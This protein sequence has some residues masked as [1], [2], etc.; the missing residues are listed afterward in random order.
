MD[1]FE[2]GYDPLVTYGKRE[3]GTVPSGTGTGTGSRQVDLW[4]NFAGDKT[5][6]KSAHAF[7][8]FLAG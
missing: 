7:K 1:E 2:G 3:P 8:R 4:G 6:R 5:W